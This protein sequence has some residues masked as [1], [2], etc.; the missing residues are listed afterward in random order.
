VLAP[1]HPDIAVTLNSMAGL[2]RD[3]GRFAEAEP[4]YRRAL[5]IRERAL[6]P[7]NTSVGETLKDYA[8]LLRRT[9]RAREA[10]ALEE[11]AARIH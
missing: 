2:L 8:E 1:T 11:R 5:A 10:A 4:L 9:G 7:D 3:Q 6:G